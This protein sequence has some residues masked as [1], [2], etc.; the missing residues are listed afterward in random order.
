VAFLFTFFLLSFPDLLIPLA[1]VVRGL[2]LLKAGGRGYVLLM[3][4]LQKN[5]LLC[6]N[7]L[8]GTRMVLDVEPGWLGYGTRMAWI[9]NQDGLDMEPGWPIVEMGMGGLRRW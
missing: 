5:L 4:V 9:W 1:S 6:I 8:Y 3:F 7:I 2:A